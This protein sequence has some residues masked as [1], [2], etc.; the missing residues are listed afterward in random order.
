[1]VRRGIGFVLAVFAAGACSDTITVG[2]HKYEEVYIEDDQN[3]YFIH[4]PEEGQ[5]LKVSRKRKDVSTPLIEKDATVRKALRQRYEKNRPQPTQPSGKTHPDSISNQSIEQHL[6]VRDCALFEAQLT[7]WKHLTQEQRIAIDRTLVAK[8]LSEADDFVE[9]IGAI[10]G[11]PSDLESKLN[12]IAEHYAPELPQSKISSTPRPDGYVARRNQRDF[13][14]LKYRTLEETSRNISCGMRLEELDQALRTNYVPKLDPDVAQEWEGS[15][16]KETGHFS[17][18][19]PFWR[20]DCFRD[21]FGKVDDFAITIYDAKTDR[22]FTRLGQADF[23]QMRVRVMEGPGSYYLKIEQ[24]KLQIP[25][26]I[27]AVTFDE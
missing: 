19:K 21:D 8:T 7:H 18:D 23:L 22:P 27:H 9:S 3:H 26:E 14:A 24:G 2:K 16:S 5:V 6:N 17:I 25:Y 12:E 4:L 15:A 20:L 11:D 13:K 1:M 10:G